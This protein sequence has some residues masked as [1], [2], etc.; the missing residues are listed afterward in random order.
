MDCEEFLGKPDLKIPL[1]PFAKGKNFKITDIDFIAAEPSLGGRTGSPF[2]N[3]W[4]PVSTGMTAFYEF[5]KLKG[6]KWLV[7]QSLLKNG[8]C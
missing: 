1:T 4:I 8:E 6:G 5:I 2:F 7:V 3:F